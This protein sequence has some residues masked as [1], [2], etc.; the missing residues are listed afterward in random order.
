RGNFAL[1]W[2]QGKGLGNPRYSAWSQQSSNSWI[3]LATLLRD[4]TRIDVS[5][6][7]P[8]GFM[9]ALSEEELTRATTK[10]RRVLD[11]PGVPQYDIE[12]LDH[13]ALAR[14]LPQIGPDVVGSTYCPLDG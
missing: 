8:G 1:V 4:T 6:E 11:Q 12:V 5:F 13:A 10:L 14:M 2:V 9:P 7:R 3:R